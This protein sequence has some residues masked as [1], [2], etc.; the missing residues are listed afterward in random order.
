MPQTHI[1][2]IDRLPNAAVEPS[3]EDQGPA[4]PP[5]SP[6]CMGAWW[7]TAFKAWRVEPT[8]Q[9]EPITTPTKP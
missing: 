6:E 1:D 8:T 5:P 4:T 7:D 3:S 2:C 9:T